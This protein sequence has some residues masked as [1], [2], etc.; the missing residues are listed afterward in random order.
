[1]YLGSRRIRSAGRTSGSIEITLPACLQ[2][3]EGVGCQLMVRGGPRPEILLQPDLSEAQAVFRTLWEKLRS[4]LM[5]IG[6][7]GDFSLAD[8]TLDL[9]P[10]RHWQERPPLAYADALAALRQQAGPDNT[11]AEASTRLVAFLAVGAGHRLGLERRLALAFGDAVAYLITGLPT[12]LGT[13]FER[14]MAHRVFWGAGHPR[15]VWG[16]PFDAQVWQWA[17]PGLRRVYEQF[18]RWQEDSEAYDTARQRWYRA[19]DVEMGLQMS[20]VEEQVGQWQMADRPSA[21]SY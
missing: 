8:F 9:F 1:M 13:D 5:E 3:L 6:E 7:I 21:L 2:V 17:R 18:H 15:H 14:G 19:L 12:G 20:S 10:P 4:G 11:E 16:S